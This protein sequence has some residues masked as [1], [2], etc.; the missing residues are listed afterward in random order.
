VPVASRATR[1][2]RWAGIERELR[3]TYG[4]LLAGVDEVGRG[5]L[6]GPVVACAI[7]MPPNRRAIAGVDDS[8]A[9]SGDER[10]RLARLIRDRA[11]A[12]GIGAASVREIERLNIYH[13]STLAMR[14]ALTRLRVTPH[15]VVVDGRAIATLG[16]QHTA[17][18]GGDA[19]CFSVACASIIAKVTRDRLMRS[20]ALRYPL[21]G[22]EHNVGYATREHL[23]CLEEHG[24]TCHHRRSFVSCRQLSFDF[25]DD[26]E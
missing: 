26:L 15:H 5:P 8:K 3:H 19:R 1:P 4:P 25:S 9:L 22:W 16:V 24:L 20:L 2:Q 7:I 18:V 23:S 17:V 6:A 11:L 12:I 21:Y 14:R 10:E 13:A